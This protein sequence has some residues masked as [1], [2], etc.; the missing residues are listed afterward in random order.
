MCDSK[1]QMDGFQ[2]GD[3]LTINASIGNKASNEDNLS[4]VA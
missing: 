2:F 4:C 1:S 3:Q